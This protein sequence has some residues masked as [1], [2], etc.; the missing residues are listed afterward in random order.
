MRAIDVVESAVGDV[1]QTPGH[2]RR[3]VI[4]HVRHV[5]NLRELLRDHPQEK[6]PRVFFP[7]EC[8]LH[9]DVGIEAE[10]RVAP[11]PPARRRERLLVPASGSGRF[12]G[13]TRRCSPASRRQQ[14]AAVAISAHDL[15]RRDDRRAADQLTLIPTKS[16]ALKSRAQLSRTSLSPVSVVMPASH[17]RLHRRRIGL[18]GGDVD[19]LRRV[20][21]HHAAGIGPRHAGTATA[22]CS[23]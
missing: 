9:V 1:L 15:R 19:A 17:H 5:D 21:R 7:L 16:C 22:P 4:L 13:P 6:R 2:A 10:P 11:T 23:W 12:R 8:S 18:L 20:H 3:A 14:R